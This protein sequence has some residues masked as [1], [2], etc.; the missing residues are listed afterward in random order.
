M[1]ALLDIITIT[2]DDLDG[3]L[4]TRESIRSLLKSPEVRQLIIDGSSAEVKKHTEETAMGEEN[5][6][7][8]WYQPSGISSAFN[9]GL[10]L[11]TSEWVW[12]LNG[13]DTFHPSMDCN[14][15]LNILRTSNAE[16][17]IFQIETKQSH[18]RC[19]HPPM[20]EIWPPVGS[21]IPHPATIVKRQLFTRYGYFDE[22]YRIAMDYEM[23]LRLFSKYVIV[24]LISM[25][26]VLYDEAGVSSIRR[27][28][29]MKEAKR[30][31]L[32]KAW[33]LVKRW[34]NNGR[35]IYRVIR[36]YHTISRLP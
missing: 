25:P 8:A 30:I 9:H 34:L 7:Y 29:S 33:M 24:D 16:A 36:D 15:L 4:S 14:T 10:D 11:A 23:W 6:K 18:T 2:K 26:I 35:M 3:L 19:Q 28:E 5:V 20:W 17:I 22:Q 27:K 1:S 13:G 31:L 32:S 21:W 12:F